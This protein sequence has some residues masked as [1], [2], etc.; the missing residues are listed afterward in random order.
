MK[1]PR[2]IIF[3]TYLNYHHDL[4]QALFAIATLVT[5]FSNAASAANGGDELPSAGAI[6]DKVES[7][8]PLVDNLQADIRWRYT[9][10]DK[11]VEVYTQRLWSDSL[12]RFR[13]RVTKSIE[14]IAQELRT[15]DDIFDGGTSYL[16]T[17]RAD[18]PHH[19]VIGVDSNGDEPAGEM[20]LLSTAIYN[21]KG[22]DGQDLVM[23]RLPNAIDWCSD[24]ARK[25]FDKAIR[26][27]AEATVTESHNKDLSCREYVIEFTSKG[28]GS[29]KGYNIRFS[30][31]PD[32]G[33]LVTGFHRRALGNGTDIH[34]DLTKLKKTGGVWMPYGSRSRTVN[35]ASSKE[36]FRWEAD[37]QNLVVNSPILDDDTFSFIG[38]PGSVVF[39]HRYDVRYRVPP[40]GVRTDQLAAVAL[41]VSENDPSMPPLTHNPFPHGLEINSNADSE[42]GNRPN[43]T[44]VAI[45]VAV[46]VLL[47]VALVYRLQN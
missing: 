28:V 45:N 21:G 11:P 22:A 42:A 37:F 17:F 4:F 5:A 3:H 18:V 31:A 9:E 27:G 40:S 44:L 13:S 26:N 20:G 38:A 39:D 46:I 10:L 1:N 47:L 14:G 30:V 23:T 32:R 29:S 24:S 34:Q 43:H 7:R 15:Y 33:Y 19:G 36:W 16:S 6:M 41:R 8:F 25:C 2:S 35:S 12:G